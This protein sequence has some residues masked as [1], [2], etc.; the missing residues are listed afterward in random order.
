MALSRFR[1]FGMLVGGFCQCLPANV[2]HEKISSSSLRNYRSS[3]WMC[4]C[5]IHGLL[6]GECLDSASGQRGP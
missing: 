1:T 4:K 2:S 3:C 6:Y 5:K